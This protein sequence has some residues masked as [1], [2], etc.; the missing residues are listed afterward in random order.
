FR[1]LL[2]EGRTYGFART[3][4]TKSA[5]A[6]F[7]ADTQPTTFTL[8]GEALSAAVPEGAGTVFKVIAGPDWFPNAGSGSLTSGQTLDLGQ[9]AVEITLPPL[10]GALLA[11]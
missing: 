4:G 11:N 5:V 7:N 6:L 3:L 2:T 8:D 1:T 10:S 9:G